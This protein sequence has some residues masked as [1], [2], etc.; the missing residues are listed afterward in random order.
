MKLGCGDNMCC[1]STGALEPLLDAAGFQ[2]FAEEVL[3]TCCVR[4]DVEL[5]ASVLPPGLE[6]LEDP[7]ESTGTPIC[8][9]AAMF[10]GESTLS[11]LIPEGVGGDRGY[12]IKGA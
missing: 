7:F 2:V 10:Q 11:V 4:V 6:L 12:F 1:G 8:D 5:D 9:M 3:I